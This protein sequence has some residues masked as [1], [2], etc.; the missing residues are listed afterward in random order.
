[1]A[2]YRIIKDSCRI[3]DRKGMIVD[4]FALYFFV[5]I[6]FFGAWGICNLRFS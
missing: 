4:Y 5:I 1:M 3:C 2:S 6:I